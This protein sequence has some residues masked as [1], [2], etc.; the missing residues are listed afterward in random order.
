MHN[1]IGAPST[2]HGRP[3]E[4]T[5]ALR[6]VIF[7]FGMVL[8]GQP[9]QDAH[10]AMIRI[11]GLPVARFEELYWA[12]RHAYDEGRLTG[13]MFWQNFVRDAK[14]SLQPEQID[15]LN[16]QD[17]RMWSTQNPRMLAWQLQ[18]KQHGLRTAI[19]SNMG[20]SVLENL[21]RKFDWLP[22]FDVLIWSF[23]HRM[24]KPD[25]A[26]YKLTLT[27]LGTKAEE[28]LFIDDKQVNIDAAAKLGMPGILFSTI[29][30]LRSQLIST[31]LDKQLPLPTP[32]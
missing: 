16:R 14:L 5:L 12:D 3:R 24:A 8:T 9:D 10:A 26:I 23:Q 15:E 7:D 30:Q 25:P 6:A 27:R 29:E 19:L 31:G 18:L 22:R 11:T 21:E 13:V 28:T 4:N 20:D 2:I 32:S 17:V 1:G